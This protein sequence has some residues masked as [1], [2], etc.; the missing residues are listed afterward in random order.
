MAAKTPD[1]DEKRYLFTDPCIIDLF[2]HG[3]NGVRAALLY[4]LPGR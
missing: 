2:L 3:L 1:S 4:L